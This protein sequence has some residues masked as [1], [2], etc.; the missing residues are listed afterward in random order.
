MQRL[1]LRK[2]VTTVVASTYDRGLTN[3]NGVWG[4]LDY[5]YDKQPPQ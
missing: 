5:T 2:K 4:M 1:G 3:S